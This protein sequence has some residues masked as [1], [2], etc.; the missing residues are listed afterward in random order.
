MPRKPVSYAQMMAAQRRESGRAVHDRDYRRQ[1]RDAS[2]DPVTAEADRLRSSGRWKRL[3]LV[4]LARDPLCEEC[5]RHDVTAFAVDVDHETPVVEL[6]AQGRRADV[7]DLAGL[8][9]LCRSCHNQK[10]AREVAE[11]S[12][13]MRSGVVGCGQPCQSNGHA[14]ALEPNGATHSDPNESVSRDAPDAREGRGEGSPPAREPLAG[15]ALGPPLFSRVSP[16]F[17]EPPGVGP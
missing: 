14:G 10:T 2:L 17:L 11:R 9:S 4:K 8:N 12:G 1:R 15:G 13:R 6:L 5:L 3:R 16:R 7:F